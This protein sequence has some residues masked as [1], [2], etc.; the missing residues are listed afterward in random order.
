MASNH[1]EGKEQ[2]VVDKLVLHDTQF[3]KKHLD[4]FM[5]KV[6]KSEGYEESNLLVFSNF[7]VT[8][9]AVAAAVVSHFVLKD[10]KTQQPLM[11]LCIAIWMV[12]SVVLSVTER[13]FGANFSGATYIGF[14]DP[15]RIGTALPFKFI[16]ATSTLPKYSQE[17]TLKLT[18]SR[19]QKPLVE[20]KLH[21]NDYYTSEGQFLKAKFESQVKKTI[22]ELSSAKTK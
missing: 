20:T 19:T 22:D 17:Y 10:F 16:C 4:D 14:A 7:T 21:Y 6:L 13:M 3:I 12:C 8:L 1:E 15:K 9:I 11:I 18:P 5:M 2:L